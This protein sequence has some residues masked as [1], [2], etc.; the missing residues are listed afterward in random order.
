MARQRWRH[1]VAV[2]SVVLALGVVTATLAG[3]WRYANQDQPDVID[4]PLVVRTSNAACLIM[5]KSVHSLAPP[6]E[7][8]IPERVEA[9]L[10]QNDAVN[11]MLDQIRR[12]GPDRVAGDVPLPEWIND[13]EALVRARKD[14]AD[15]LGA[16][17][18]KQLE[19]PVDAEGVPIIKRMNEV[20]LTCTVPPELTSTG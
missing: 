19:L 9:I 13:W 4:S 14:Y 17:R 11:L 7:A 2:V 16:G 1:W 10:Q 18:Q 5:R 15:A 12:V 8:P 20:G 6:A 3:L